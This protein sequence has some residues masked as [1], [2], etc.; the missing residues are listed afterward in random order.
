MTSVGG[1][2]LSKKLLKLL[3]LGNSTVGKTS[4]MLRFCEQT[5]SLNFSPTIGVDYKF[6]TVDMDGRR[7]KLQIWDTAGQERFKAITQ[8]Y[9]RMAA[10][11]LLVYDVTDRASFTNVQNWVESIEANTRPEDN[12]QFVLV[13]NKIDCSAERMVS[14]EEGQALACEYSCDFFECSAATGDNVES[15]FLKL[16]RLTMA[17]GWGPDADGES[18]PLA[19]GTAAK[20][21]CCK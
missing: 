14:T 1:R 5:F 20:G 2:E 13:G 16:A 11:I 12:C 7:V 18:M 17:E 9:Y 21:G 10:G 4:L 15:A 3:L 6:K 8:R 19:P